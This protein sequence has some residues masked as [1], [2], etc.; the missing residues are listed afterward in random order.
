MIC[1]QHIKR[2]MFESAKCLGPHVTAASH[3]NS[4]FWCQS[5]CH[6]WLHRGKM[7]HNLQTNPIALTDPN[8]CFT[9][10]GDECLVCSLDFGRQYFRMQCSSSWIHNLKAIGV[11]LWLYH[12]IRLCRY[13][14]NSWGQVPSVHLCTRLSPLM[15][16]AAPQYS[17]LQA[18][19]R[20][21]LPTEVEL[22]LNP[23]RVHP[24][25][26]GIHGNGRV[27]SILE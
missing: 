15:T 26:H 6:H 8:L 22:L 24:R 16:S 20:H 11:I 2:F 18:S 9:R 17:P 13:Y 27:Q 3:S 1:Q 4:T 12:L 19:S 14:P 23:K 5:T 21:C 25:P 10:H 7:S